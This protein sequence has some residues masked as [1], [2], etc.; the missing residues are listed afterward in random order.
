MTTPTFIYFDMGN[1]LLNFHAAAP[2]RQIAK[3]LNLETRQLMDFFE[4]GQYLEALE[5][6][7]LS[8]QDVLTAWSQGDPSRNPLNLPSLESIEHA[9]CDIFSIHA[10]MVSLISQLNLAGIPLG[11]LSNTNLPHWNYVTDGRFGILPSLFQVH[12][13]SFQIGVMKPD[14]AIYAAAAEL[15]GTSPNQIFFT[16]DREE[17]VAAA[18]S[19]GW[20]VHHFDGHVPHLAAE[21]KR[22]GLQFNY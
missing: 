19:Q 21:L 14:V 20:Q 4:R 12:A 5:T 6:G 3:V 17:N 16:D 10:P 2:C 8:P 18:A 7:Q 15:A 13:L 22:R 11:I 9:G 1:V